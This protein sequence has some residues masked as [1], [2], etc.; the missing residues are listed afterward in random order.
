MLHT[1]GLVFRTVKYG[2]TS[3]I[4]DIYTQSK[5]LQTF[6]I[7]GVRKA[8]TKFSPSL[9]QVMS[10][11][12]IVSYFRENKEMHRM[13]ELRSAFWYETISVDVVKSSVGLFMLEVSQKSIKEAEE[14]PAL[15]DFLWNS[16]TQ[17]DQTKES[18]ANFPLVFMMGLAGYLG[19]MPGGEQPGPN[20]VFDLQE[21][22]FT[23]GNPG[24]TYYLSETETQLWWKILQLDFKHAHELEI[25]KSMRK[26]LL[27]QFI[28]YYRLHIEH[29][30]EP[31]AHKILESIF[32]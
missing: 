21:G 12:E 13:K 5:G 4:A 22:I 26:Q 32:Q 30:K 3:I 24:H 6:I 28:I 16:F 17:L 14:N 1:K 11:V 10:L 20:T 27:N 29:F 8:K 7:G 9:L 23:D 18:L 15:F 2:E 19:F 31:K 25:E